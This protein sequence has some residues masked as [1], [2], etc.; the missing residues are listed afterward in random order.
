MRAHSC[1]LLRKLLRQPETHITQGTQT[2]ESM[3]TATARQVVEIEAYLPAES[4]SPMF[5]SKPFLEVP[6]VVEY[7]QPTPV[8]EHM[9]NAC[10]VLDSSAHRCLSGPGDHID[11]GADSLPD[12]SADRHGANRHCDSVKDTP[13]AQQSLLPTAK[14]VQ[15][16]KEI[17]H[18]G[19]RACELATCSGNGACGVHTCDQVHRVGDRSD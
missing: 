1:R 17:F 8:V 2:S 12:Y 4:A 5:V 10:G 3:G 11:S 14:T 13:V 7:V 19:G 9:A 18:G 6:F 15:K 16:T